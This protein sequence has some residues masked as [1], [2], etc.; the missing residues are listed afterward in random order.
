MIFIFLFNQTK[1]IFFS[2]TSEIGFLSNQ[3]YHFSHKQFNFCLINLAQGKTIGSH[4]ESQKATILINNSRFQPVGF[5]IGIL[6]H[7]S[8]ITTVRFNLNVLGLPLPS[9]FD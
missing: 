8:G 6:N 3:K 4:L 1:S 5:P 9:L 7:Q 2:Y